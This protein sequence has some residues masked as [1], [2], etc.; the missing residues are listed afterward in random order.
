[1]AAEVGP[2]LPVIGVYVYPLWKF[3]YNAWMDKKSM[4]S[5]EI[6]YIVIC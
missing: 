5:L 3:L 4:V 6:G 1:M 2:Y